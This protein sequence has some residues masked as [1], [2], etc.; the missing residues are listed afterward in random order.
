[1]VVII[2]D[3]EFDSSKEPIAILF[4]NDEERKTVGNQIG[5]MPDKDSFR[6]YCLYPEDRMEP[7]QIHQMFDELI[8]RINETGVDKFF[9]GEEAG[10]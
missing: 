4:K 3:K 9:G 1:M 10:L 5:N 7:E 6:I 2:G 8:K